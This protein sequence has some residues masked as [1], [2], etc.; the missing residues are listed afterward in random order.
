M[1]R[2]NKL[3]EQ[4]IDPDNLREAFWKAQ[5]G[6]S[7]AKA[8]QQFRVDLG[9]NLM[10]LRTEIEQGQVKVGD[11][12]FFK[13]YEPK[14]REIC[15]PA[16]REQVLHHSLMNICHA[17]F[18]R[19]QIYDSYASRKGKGTY[20]ALARA[21]TY[22]LKYSYFLKLDVKAFFASIHHDVL[23]QQLAK[24]FKDKQLLN[25]L[26]TIIDSYPSKDTRGLPIGNL[27]SQ[28]FANHYLSG[29]D[30]FIYEELPCKAYVRYMDDMIVW[31]NDKVV[32][33]QIH[34][35]IE[36][37]VE[38]RLGLKLKPALLNKTKRGLPFL[39]YLIHP[40]HTRL[41]QQSKQRYIKKLS[42][43]DQNYTAGNWSEAHCQQK[44]LPLIAFTR[45]ADTEIFRKNVL[46]RIQGQS[47]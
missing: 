36:H 11:Y 26:S 27:T 45:H 20:A 10:Q 17:Y 4:I 29:L 24:L 23:K 34:V 5:K 19:K 43:I 38:S 2:P 32:L 12:R 16:F 22:T 18:E 25:I 37:F 13:I 21:R 40:N 33:K 3:I 30:H 44:V 15:A 8:V 42:I 6:K 41:S 1:K 46:L 47:S 14:E 28:Y 39:G 7:Y 31:H 9:E 35:A